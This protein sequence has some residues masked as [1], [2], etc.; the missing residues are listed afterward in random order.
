[1]FHIVD[2]CHVVLRSRGVYKQAKV[3][4]YEGKLFAG[5]SGGF[6][7]LLGMFGDLGGTSAPNVSWLPGEDV[8]AGKRG[9]PELTRG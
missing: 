1:M 8:R 4:R 5:Y 2:D 7:R 3:Y 6:I 9:F